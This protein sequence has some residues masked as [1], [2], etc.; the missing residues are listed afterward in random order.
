VELVVEALSAVYGEGPLA[1]LKLE[2]VL[3]GAAA[4]IAEP[5]LPFEQST[6]SADELAWAPWSIRLSP[7]AEPVI[8]ETATG[9]KIA[10][11]HGG[12]LEAFNRAL[13]LQ[14]APD[15]L[16]AV[17]AEAVFARVAEGRFELD[18]QRRGS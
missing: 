17:R 11:V 16:E 13:L 8:Y 15:L 1:R 5:G 18:Q 12:E 2:L 3:G 9:E 14:R 7:G 10:T 6:P 4:P